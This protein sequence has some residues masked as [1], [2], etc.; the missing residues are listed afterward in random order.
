MASHLRRHWQAAA[1]AL[2]ICSSAGFLA[3]RAE[4]ADVKPPPAGDAEVEAGGDLSDPAREQVAPEAGKGDTAATAQADEI[5]AL[6]ARVEAAE[7][8]IQL[9]KSVVVQAL[10]AQS[11]AEAT[12]RRER[13][14]R[15]VAPAAGPGASG[16]TE[17]MLADQLG[18]VTQGLDRLREDVAALRAEVLSGRR[19]AAG[20]APAPEEAEPA[21]SAEADP[22]AESGVGGE[23]DPLIQG[24]RVA[25]VA[26]DAAADLGDQ[27]EVGWVHFD[28][29][30]AE[31]TPGGQRKALEAAE[32][33]KAMEA[34]KVRVVGHADTV[35]EA[36][37]N[38]QLSE[39]RAR[40]IAGL[41]ERVG[42][43][44]DLVEIVGRGED[45]AP[46]PTADQVSEPLN[47]CAGIFVVMDSPK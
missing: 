3:F 30:S 45:G 20:S 15:D 18:A 9:L 23:Y 13:E 25:A 16:S 10:R 46:V 19:P 39:R 33:I 1:A 2:L 4:P 35:G 5:R 6:R 14:A 34:A 22:L 8:Q 21:A 41:L 24:E 7:S 28:S 43:S 31:L 29:G 12:L 37:H 17:P 32:R 40:A 11:A 36:G 44:G 26:D 42:L 27:M 47:R 38:R